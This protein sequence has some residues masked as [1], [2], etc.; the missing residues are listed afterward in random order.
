MDLGPAKYERYRMI[1]NIRKAKR[2]G[3]GEKHSE[4]GTLYAR[5]VVVMMKYCSVRRLAFLMLLA[6]S[7]G[8]DAAVVCVGP[9]TTGNGSGTNWSNLKAWSGTPARGDTW[10]LADGSYGA[11]NFTTAASGSTLI[12]IKKATV[13]DHGE[14]SAGWLDT[15]G[16]GQ[17]VFTPP[18]RFG[19]SYWV[20]DG[21]RSVDWSTTATDY[22]FALA[23]NVSSGFVLGTATGQTR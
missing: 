3:A 22:G 16:D 4:S 19:T 23:A 1:T 10:Y 13:A 21:T 7:S 11:K 17:A 5:G 20:F 15:M 14:V 18:I 9:A 8:A 2:I 6:I 12:T